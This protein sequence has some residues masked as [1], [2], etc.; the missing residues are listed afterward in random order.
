MQDLSLRTKVIILLTCALVVA[1]SVTGWIF[2]ARMRSSGVRQIEQIRNEALA[3]VTLRLKEEVAVGV[4]IVDAFKDSSDIPEA[5]ARQ[6]IRAK[7][8]LRDI[9]FGGS[10]YYFAYDT[11]GVCMVLGPK[12]DWEGQ[13]KID[14]KDP[15]EKYYVRDL[16]KAARTSGGDTV[17][18]GFSKP[19]NGQ[20]I[21][22]IAYAAGT[23]NWGWLVGTGVYVDDIDS[24][25]AQRKAQISAE[26]GHSILVGSL[27]TL[28]AVA[29][30]IAIGIA[31]TRRALIPLGKLQDRM[32][33]IS[34]G[35]KDLTVRLTT[36]SE[37]EV[38]ITSKAFNRFLGSIAEFVTQIVTESGKVARSSAQVRQA[39]DSTSGGMRNIE[40]F[41]SSIAASGEQASSSI[42]DI[43]N[44]SEESSSS[45]SSVSAALEEMTASIAEIARSS[46]QE[47]MVAREANRIT[48]E[49]RGKIEHLVAVAKEAGTVLET[50]SEVAEQT[51][52]LALNATIEAARAGEAG[53]GFAVVA[54][55]VKDLAKQAAEATV[56]IR[57]RIEALMSETGVAS[58]AIQSVAQEVD[59][60]DML[61]QTIGSALEEQSSTV[62]DIARNVSVV[63]ERSLL[64]AR[65]TV[66]S[67]LGLEEISKSIAELH[68]TVRD[69]NKTS[70]DLGHASN[71]LDQ[72]ASAL[73]ARTGEFRV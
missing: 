70:T 7:T 39:A 67:A 29:L 8:V 61:S 4:G 56:S 47:L 38:G 33:S 32:V 5:S 37:D 23:A 51:K 42:R 9:R 71:D 16:I 64:V 54:S 59:K 35:T 65:N 21:P 17:H 14:I 50:I 53:K 22:K 3:Q 2:V 30:L 73:V 40:S 63:Q 60:V 41:A 26:I 10:G 28:L 11:N 18:Y 24:L 52:L 6:Q 36:D 19:P 12:P 1:C 68:A 25:V 49:A 44:A 34:E 72:L 58:R 48:E 45:I 31:L 13:S 57:E 20:I 66:Q 69:A 15:S 27:V 43:A 62:Q 46:Q 55:E